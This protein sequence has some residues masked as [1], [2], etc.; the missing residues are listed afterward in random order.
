MPTRPVTSGILV[1]TSP[2]SRA[3]SGSNRMSRLVMMPSSFICGSTTGTPEM[4]KRAHIASASPMVAS[5]EMVIGSSIIPASERLTTSTWCAWSSMDR[6]RWMMPSPP[7]RAIATAIRDSVTVSIGEETRGTWTVI[8]FDTRD[9]VVTW[10]GMTS[11]SAGCSS[12]SS[13]VSPSRS[14]GS[15]TPAAL[16]SS[17][18]S[19]AQPFARLGVGPHGISALLV[20]TARRRCG[21]RSP[22]KPAPRT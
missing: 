20:V 3:G 2:T 6:L 12:T 13:K 21:N 18:G 9:D 17:D 10:E 14:K 16:R 1:I 19:T 11:L 5:G 15:G 4:W 7:C 22:R 8:R